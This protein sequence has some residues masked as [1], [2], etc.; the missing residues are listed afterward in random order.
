MANSLLAGIGSGRPME[1]AM[2]IPAE[3]PSWYAS[4]RNMHM[5][6]E[7]LIKIRFNSQSRRAGPN[8]AQGR[9]GR[10]LHD[11]RPVSR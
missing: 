5:D 1:L 11:P 10:F 8:V 6:V 9:L 4:L 2:V 3:G 7:F